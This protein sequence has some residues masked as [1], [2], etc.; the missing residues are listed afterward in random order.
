MSASQQTGCQILNIF[1]NTCRF[2]PFGAILSVKVLH[3]EGTTRCR[4]VCFVN[5][6]TV[7]GAVAAIQAMN[8]RKVGDKTLHVS[9]Q[10]RK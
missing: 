3:E 4:G 8:G 7:E 10:T 1:L 9:I 6:T 5:Y 2:A